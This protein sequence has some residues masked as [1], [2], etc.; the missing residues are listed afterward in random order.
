VS[1]R[2]YA[3]GSAGVGFKP[4]AVKGLMHPSVGEQFYSTRHRADPPS[5]IPKIDRQQ[6]AQ[7]SQKK[8][9]FWHGFLSIQI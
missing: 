1:G 2:I 7:S 5:G 6:H 3:L 8:F 4:L 9:Q